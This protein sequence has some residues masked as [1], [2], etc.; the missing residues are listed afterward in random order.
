[1]LNGVL[2]GTMIF[3]FCAKALQHQAFNSDGNTVGSDIFGATM[4]TCIVWVVNLQWAI[5]MKYL[6]F[7]HHLAMWTSIVLWYFFMFM[8]G[9]TSPIQSTNAYKVFVEALAPT[10]SYWLVTLFVVTVC[11][12]PYFSYVAV[13]TRF[14]PMYHE[15]IQWIRN[16]GKT[17]DPEY[18]EMVRQRSLR[19][20]TVGFTARVAART[21]RT[22][23]RNRKKTS[24]ELVAVRT[25]SRTTQTRHEV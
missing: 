13:Q 25:E 4:Y 23:D 8:Y 12:I 19:P 7:F 11:L 20:T 18:C 15:M 2:S 14:F 17:N 24:H 5:A 6:T 1:M 10:P 21:S 16:E 3:F 22:R 9:N